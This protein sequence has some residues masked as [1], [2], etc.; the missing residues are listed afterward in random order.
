MKLINGSWDG[1]EL[2]YRD[3]VLIHM[4]LATEWDGDRP[5]K[6]ARSGVAIYEPSDCGKYAYWLKNCWDGTTDETY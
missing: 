4:A 1:Y 6:G 2:V 3:T 5:A